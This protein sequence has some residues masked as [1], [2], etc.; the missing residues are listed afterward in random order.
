M[1]LGST[2]II[3]APF[4]IALSMREPMIEKRDRYEREVRALV[5]EGMRRGEFAKADAAL[6][7]RAKEALA[8]SGLAVGWLLDRGGEWIRLALVVAAA[9]NSGDGTPTYPASYPGVISVAALA[10]AGFSQDG[11]G[12]PPGAR[13]LADMLRLFGGGIELTTL[14]AIP[15]GSGLGTSSI[16][17]AVL[18]A[19][20]QRCGDE[21]NFLPIKLC[22]PGSDIRPAHRPRSS[23]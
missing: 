8:A 23:G 20:V 22:Q 13:T 21:H 15:S 12:W 10:L 9:G 3:F 16:M 4:S 6:V 5:A 14:A 7:T 18:T 17:G 2:T 1:S 19:V 11:E